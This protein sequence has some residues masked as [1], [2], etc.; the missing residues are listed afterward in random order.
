MSEAI[1]RSH[2]E[3]YSCQVEL[4]TRLQSFEQHSDHVDAQ[5]IKTTEDGQE[6]SETVS[7]R[8]LLGCDGARSTLVIA[9]VEIDAEMFVSR[10]RTEEPGIGFPRGDSRGAKNCHW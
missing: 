1:L 2:I 10:F 7:V 5:L 8:F 3:K 6:I 4:A 9:V